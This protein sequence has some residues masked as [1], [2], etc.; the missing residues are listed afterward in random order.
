ME[1]SYTPP[2]FRTVTPYLTVKGADELLAFIKHVFEAEELACH[3]GEHG[4]V[5][6]A[7]VRI[8]DSTIEL[9]EATSEWRAAPSALHIYVPDCDATHAR[10]V[11]AGATVL[12]G[13]IDQEYGERSSA[14]RD[15]AG[16][17]W[18]IATYKRKPKG[19]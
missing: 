19:T 16:N 13:P 9:S 14:V 10:A 18:Y 6:N 17:S 4:I 8:G 5:M 2:G 11:A 7:A 1:T 3:R 15:L 12:H